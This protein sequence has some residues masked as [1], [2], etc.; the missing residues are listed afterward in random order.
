MGPLT[1]FWGLQP[2]GPRMFRYLLHHV[3]RSLD[4]AAQVC[5][6]VSWRCYTYFCSRY[7]PR[8]TRP[9]SCR[10]LHYSLWQPCHLKVGTSCSLICVQMVRRLFDVLGFLCGGDGPNELRLSPPL[11]ASIT[12][13]RC[14]LWIHCSNPGVFPEGP[15]LKPVRDACTC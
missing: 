15:Y 7:P 8:I 13:H 2:R 4:P 9:A 6:S 1:G 11:N 12:L 14:V 10:C 3:P 5:N